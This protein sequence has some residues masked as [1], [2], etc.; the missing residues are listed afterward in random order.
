MPLDLGTTGAEAW[1]L[2]LV[3]AAVRDA[4]PRLA[5]LVPD[6]QNPTGALLDGAGANSSSRSPAGPAPRC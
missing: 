1:D 3:T 2:D 4:A 6:H 5:Y